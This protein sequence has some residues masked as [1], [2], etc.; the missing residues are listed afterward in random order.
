MHS[1]KYEG[2]KELGIFMGVMCA[3]DLL[4]TDFFEGIDLLVPVPMHAAKIK[5]RGYNQAALIAEGI[6]R[7]TGRPFS[8]NLLV[9]N[10]NT[11]SQTKMNRLD[12]FENVRASFSVNNVHDSS[13]EH[14]LLIDDVITTGSTLEACGLALQ[15][16]MNCRLSI[17][18]LA[19]TD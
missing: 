15:D 11:E 19:A 13:A 4:K 17:L 9:K 7:V 1:I 10:E 16:G 3:R 12:R 14:I 8:E 6:S 5:K 18:T 2:N